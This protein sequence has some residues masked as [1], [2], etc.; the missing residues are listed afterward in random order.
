[1]A[2]L[3]VA[4]SRGQR[5][6]Y[7]PPPFCLLEDGMDLVRHTGWLGGYSEPTS[8]ETRH[9]RLHYSLVG[10]LNDLLD[11]PFLCSRYD[12][13]LNRV[14]DQTKAPQLK[15]SWVTSQPPQTVT[16]YTQGNWQP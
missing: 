10:T 13:Y 9:R 8:E 4:S 14:F 12:F 1:M 7:I 16:H 15:L 5:G 3:G 11:M 2:Y 6:T